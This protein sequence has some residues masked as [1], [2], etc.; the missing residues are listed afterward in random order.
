MQDQDVIYIGCKCIKRVIFIYS[1]Y[2]IRWILQKEWT[3]LL[4]REQGGTQ[5]SWGGEAR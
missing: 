2:S 3:L 4:K 1:M 5:R